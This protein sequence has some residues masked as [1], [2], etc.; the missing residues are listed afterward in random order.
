[1]FELRLEIRKI[2][3]KVILQEAGT[4]KVLFKM[5]IPEDIVKLKE[6]FKNNRHKLYLVGGSVR[7]AVLGVKPKD[8][9]LATDAKPDEVLMMVRPY[10]KTLEVGK[11]FGVINVFT[12]S[13]E[14]EIAT[15][16]VDE[17]Y[18]DNRRPDSVTFTDI[19]TDSNRRDLT[20]NALYYDID[21]QEIVDMVGGLEDLK[22]GTI[23]TVGKPEDRFGEDPLRKLRSIR[24]TARM[25]SKLSPDVAEALKKDNSLDGVSGERIRDE[26]LKGIKSAKS[27]KYFL[28]LLSDFG[29]F[30][31]VFPGL[32]ID[33]SAFIDE[34]VPEVL[35]ANI[36]RNN[37]LDATKKSMSIARYTSD[38]ISMIVLLLS[39]LQLNSTTA[40]TI[41]RLYK[42]INPNEKDVDAFAKLNN[43]DKS[44]IEALKKLVNFNVS[45]NDLI[46]QGLKGEKVG[47]EIKKREIDFFNSNLTEGTKQL[48]LMDMIKGMFKKEN[49]S[50]RRIEIKKE[51]DADY[52][53]IR[54]SNGQDFIFKR[55]LSPVFAD[56]W[57]LHIGRNNEPSNY[58]HLKTFDS[59]EVF[60]NNMAELIKPYIKKSGFLSNIAS[61][62]F[63]Q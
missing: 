49:V 62:F 21:T 63:E 4:V 52:F 18:S 23:N 30:K 31:Y 12:P 16:R 11:A 15:F 19:E 54:L 28:E 48:S 59:E 1:M 14:F 8:F 26:F 58:Q 5:E 45:G 3:E 24:F 53:L 51:E 7:D 55:N 33:T 10:Y 6:I 38:E 43:I 22:S 25:G 46:A 17:N 2:I 37:D 20:I 56:L 44:K 61:F 47:D 36:L 29:F 39:L 60:E 42:K 57:S 9:D 34:R 41:K 35:I 32:K 27:A 50:V 13:G 40:P